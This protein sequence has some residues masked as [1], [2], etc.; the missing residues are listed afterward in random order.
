MRWGDEFP[1]SGVVGAECIVQLFPGQAAIQVFLGREVL[2]GP[3]DE[4]LAHFLTELA[5]LETFTRRLDDSELKVELY[6]IGEQ[7]PRKVP[8]VEVPF[9]EK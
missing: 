8:L 9:G 4:R 6:A 3:G 2:I 1:L 5:L 7:V